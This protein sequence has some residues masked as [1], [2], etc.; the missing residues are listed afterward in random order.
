MDTKKKKNDADQAQVTRR[1]KL[2]IEMFLCLNYNE[3]F[4]DG[5]H[6]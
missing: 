4:V 5:N 6:F 1:A 2:K 3:E